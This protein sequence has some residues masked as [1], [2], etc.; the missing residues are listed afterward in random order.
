[1]RRFARLLWLRPITKPMTSPQRN[2][3]AKISVKTL[4]RDYAKLANK[5]DSKTVMAQL[6]GWFDDYNSQ[7]PHSSLGYLLPSVFR[8]K[9]SAT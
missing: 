4:K 1:M 3:M 8:Q 2:G 7:H 6:Q 9:P 5:P